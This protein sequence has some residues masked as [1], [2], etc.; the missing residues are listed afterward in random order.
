MFRKVVNY[1]SSLNF[2]R[3]LSV[4]LKNIYYKDL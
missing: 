3:N 2:K 1:I 4:A